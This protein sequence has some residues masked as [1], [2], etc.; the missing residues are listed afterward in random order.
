MPNEIAKQVQA[1][2]RM[3]PFASEILPLKK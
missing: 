3:I 1:L 2:A